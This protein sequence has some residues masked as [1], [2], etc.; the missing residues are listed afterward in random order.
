MTNSS[1]KFKVFRSSAGFGLRALRDFGKSEELIEYTGPRVSSAQGDAKPN[2]YLFQLND[3]YYIDGS[4]RANLARYINHS[5]RPNAKAFVSHDEKRITIEAIRPIKAGEEITYD[6][7]K[8]YF[9]E[10]IR[11]AGCRCVKCSGS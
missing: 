11:P 1:G 10:Y 8:E 3:R 5:C 6:Y 2:R 4:P 9:E 7:G